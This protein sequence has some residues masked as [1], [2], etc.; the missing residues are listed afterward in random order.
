[1]QEQSSDDED[2]SANFCEEESNDEE[3]VRLTDLDGVD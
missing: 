2:L 3:D 1:M